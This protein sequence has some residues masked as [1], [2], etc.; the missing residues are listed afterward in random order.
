MST[1]RAQ[2]IIIILAILLLIFEYN[3]VNKI[4][5]IT[6]AALGKSS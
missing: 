3:M 6:G 4:Y 2:S 1:G 5:S